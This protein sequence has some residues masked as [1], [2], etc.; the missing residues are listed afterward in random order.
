MRKSLRS[1]LALA[2]A[3]IALAAPVARAAAAELRETARPI[4][5]APLPNVA[6][7]R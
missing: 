7:R 1:V 6:A 2:A 5:S 3:A 4:F